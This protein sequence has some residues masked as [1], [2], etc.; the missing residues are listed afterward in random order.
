MRASRCVGGA[1]RAVVGA[2]DGELVLARAAD[3]EVLDLALV[4]S[5]SMS[6]QVV[7][8]TCRGYDYTHLSVILGGLTLLSAVVPGLPARPHRGTRR[9]R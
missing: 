5:G 3:H 6:A 2:L 4:V 1:R 8:T 9:S 7:S